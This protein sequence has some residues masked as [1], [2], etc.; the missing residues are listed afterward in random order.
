VRFHVFVG[1]DV[2][3]T[4]RGRLAD[5]GEVE[6][7][8]V[9]IHAADEAA[10]AMLPSKGPD[11]GGRMSWIRV[12]LAD[13]LPDVDRIVYL[14]ADTLVRRSVL[15]LWHALDGAPIAAV[16]NVSEPAMHRHLRSLG[17]DDATTYFNAGVL[18]IDLAAWRS[19][20]VTERVREIAASR[21]LPWFDQDALNVVFAGRW[22]RLHPRWNAMNSLWGWREHARRVFPEDELCEALDD[23][24]VL[25]FEGPQVVKPWH[26]LSRH[27]YR[28]EYRSVLHQTAWGARPLDG[29]TVVNRLI[30]RL[31][32]GR[33][34]AAYAR[35]QRARDG[36]TRLVH[37]RRSA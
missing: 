37:G 36:A 10:V 20:A 1:R 2:D 16:T 23:P 9:A 21:P 29:R 34:L 32:E 25:H 22:R 13:A 31:P 33:Q 18:A 17:F 15:S 28:D 6:G 27:P 4:A 19:D 8:S 7:A 3:A 12:V 26:Y 30:A 5:A 14:D 11:L 35:W 24:A